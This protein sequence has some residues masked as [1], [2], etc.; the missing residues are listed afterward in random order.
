MKK[1]EKINKKIA[2]VK[3][4]VYFAKQSN[5]YEKFYKLLISVDFEIDSK[6]FVAGKF[7]KIR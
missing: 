4:D 5:F 7:N 1:S 3:K 2:I 6:I